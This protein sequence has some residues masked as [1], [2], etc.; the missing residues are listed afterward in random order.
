MIG[1]PCKLGHDGGFQPRASRAG[2]K[3]KREHEHSRMTRI[4]P[5][6]AWAS[7]VSL[8]YLTFMR[9]G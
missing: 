9:V 5:T 7:C 6:Q 8:L 4:Y 1:F 2:G 3:I